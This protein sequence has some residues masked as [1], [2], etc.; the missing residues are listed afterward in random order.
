MAATSDNSLAT[1]RNNHVAVADE[2]LD[3]DDVD[4]FL[5][6]QTAVLAS[7]SAPSKR[8]PLKIWEQV[9][10]YLYPSELCRLSRVSRWLYVSVGSLRIWERWF[11]KTHGTKQRLHA[12]AR[13]PEPRS[14]MRFMCAISLLVCEECGSCAK[15]ESLPMDAPWE[16]PFP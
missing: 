12:F 13:I 14:Y 2:T 6:L 9:G 11:I 1:M 4:I 7:F 8:I 10:K 5:L 15:L 16:M 3:I